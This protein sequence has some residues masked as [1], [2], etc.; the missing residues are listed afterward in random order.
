MLLAAVG[1]FSIFD[2]ATLSL[3][4]VYG[5]QTG[6]SL[7]TAATALTFLIVGNIVLQFPLGWLADRYPHRRILMGCALITGGGLLV[8][9]MVMNSVWMWPTLVIVGATGYGV[10]TVSLTS[11]GDRFQGQELVNGSAD[12]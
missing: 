12:R 2:A 9:P 6:L 4:P 8:L 3:L 1:A 11:L 10:Y 7:S 5:I